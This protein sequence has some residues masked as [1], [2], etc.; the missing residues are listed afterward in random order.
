MMDSRGRRFRV[1][2]PHLVRAPYEETESAG[3]ISG[4]EAAAL[5]QELTDELRL[6]F[7]RA[8]LSRDL[9]Y[10]F[11]K[12]GRIVTEENRDRLSPMQHREWKRA[13]REYRRRAAADSRAIELCYSLYHERGHADLSKRRRFAASE[14]GVAVLNALD[15]EVSSFAMEGA[16]LN[17]W[18]SFA[19]RRIHLPA[20]QAERLRRRFGTGMAELLGLLEQI[21]E[22]LPGPFL[23]PVF[24]K[25]IARI[26]AARAVPE[27][28]L[29]RP[30]A[31]NAE[32][33]WETDPAF[34]HLES[35]ISFCNAA[36]VPDDVMEA[37]F[38]RFWLRSRVLNDR[39]PELFFQTLDE[40]WDNVHAR[41]QSY[42][43]RYAG[44][45]I[46]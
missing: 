2:T 29:G 20:D 9:I 38:L 44:P 15:E 27:T 30:P 33:E 24:E 23:S 45:R 10:A 1:R 16:F 6:V 35:A 42:M 13:L 5:N 14:F 21:Y 7:R 46:Q 8:N 40:K 19:F 12:T 3:A 39:M 25:R 34:E 11:A 28:W 31:S 41:V 22:E 26:E 36:D 32:A 43:T 4:A 17:A 37:M 18:L